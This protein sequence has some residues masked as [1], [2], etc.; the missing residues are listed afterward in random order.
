MK[1]CTTRM[2][3]TCNIGTETGV[4]TTD[5]NMDKDA[6][7]L[8]ERM[9]EEYHVHISSVDL[10]ENIATRMVIVFVLEL[11]VRLQQQATNRKPPTP[12]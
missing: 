9:V 8:Q 6:G 4:E 12:I 5:K 3:S 1:T 7:F 11:S 10:A 2:G